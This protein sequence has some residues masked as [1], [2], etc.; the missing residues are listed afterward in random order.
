MT[1]PHS[2]TTEARNTPVSSRTLLTPRLKGMVLLLLAILVWG[3]NWPVMKAG[4]GHVTP[5]WF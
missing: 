4:L 2:L 5:V 3:A 1:C